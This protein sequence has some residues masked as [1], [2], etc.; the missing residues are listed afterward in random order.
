MPYDLKHWDNPRA[1]IACIFKD[2][3]IGYMVH[4]HWCISQVLSF[5]DKKPS[6]LSS[7]SILDYGCGTARMSK[8]LA[9]YF[10]SV[11]A[12]D[13]NKNCIKEALKEKDKCNDGIK[14]VKNNLLHM[15]NIDHLLK[16]YLYFFD[17]IISVSVLEH[18][19]D[20]VVEKEFNRMKELLKK[21][22]IIY[23]WLHTKRN[24]LF[25]KKYL[26]NGLK[27]I[28]NN[29]INYIQIYTYTNI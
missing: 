16:H 3:D 28:N 4:A 27:I 13:P 2:N 22:G 25:I 15:S 21:D 24:E 9:H 29:I 12:Y 1:T 26:D 11:I 14:I 20:D 7:L 6:E 23:L 17:Y 5:I 18:L 19:D 10:K 8:L